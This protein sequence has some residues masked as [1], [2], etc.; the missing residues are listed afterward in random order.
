MEIVRLPPGN[1]GYRSYGSSLNGLK[2]IELG[3]GDWSDLCA[4]S[5]FANSF[6]QAG[7]CFMAAFGPFPTVPQIL[8]SSVK[9][10]CSSV[11]QFTSSL[12]A[13]PSWLGFYGL[14]SGIGCGTSG[15]NPRCTPVACGGWRKRL[16]EGNGK[17]GKNTYFGVRKQGS[18]LL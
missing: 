10:L 11:H 9:N 7:M 17:G 13:I 15:R 2:I 3:I 4:V 5:S 1:M 14:L 8:C 12:K 6:A 16:L 18:W